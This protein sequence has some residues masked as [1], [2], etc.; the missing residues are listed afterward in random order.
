MVRSTTW[1]H[2]TTTVTMQIC[3]ATMVAD[4]A[5]PTFMSSQ[6]VGE[7]QASVFTLRMLSIPA[8]HH[9]QIIGNF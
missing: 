8:V 3:M 1:R 7:W 6:A 4:M 2:M 9:H 5:E